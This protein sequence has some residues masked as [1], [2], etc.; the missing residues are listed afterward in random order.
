MN[1][2]ERLAVVRDLGWTLCVRITTEVPRTDPTPAVRD[3][4]ARILVRWSADSDVDPDTLAEMTHLGAENYLPEVASGWGP[5]EIDVGWASL[6]TIDLAVEDC[7]AQLAQRQ[8]LRLVGRALLGE[9]LDLRELRAAYPGRHRWA[10]VASMLQIDPHWRGAEYGL[11]AL[12]LAVRELGR[13][14]DVAALFPMAPGVQDLTERDVASIGLFRY[15]ARAG[16]EEF[17]GVM[18]RSLADD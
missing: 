11:V 4:D 13:R 12:D 16:F 6:A 18:A 3:H 10:L 14:A 1:E 17:N 5:R 8:D 2:A 15:W 9:R 7:W